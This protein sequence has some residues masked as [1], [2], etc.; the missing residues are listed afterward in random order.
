MQKKSYWQERSKYSLFPIMCRL[1]KAAFTECPV[2]MLVYSLVLF[3]NGVIQVVITYGTELFFDC[4]SLGAREREM[5]S[6]IIFSFLFLMAAIL[7]SHILNGCDNYLGTSVHVV[8]IGK[9]E[10]RMHKKAVKLDPALFEDTEFLDNINK[11]FQGSGVSGCTFV[12]E[13]FMVVMFSQ[14]P[15]MILMSSYLYTRKPILS[16]CIFLVFVPVVISQY[17]RIHVFAKLEDETVPCRREY[18]CYHECVTGREYF[19]ETR[20]LGAY[21]FFSGLI[22]ET[23]EKINGRAWKCYGKMAGLE[24]LMRSI[25]LLGYAGVLLLLVYYVLNGSLGVGAFAAVFS[26]IAVMFETIESAVGQQ[27]GGAFE[28]MGMVTNYVRFLDMEEMRGEEAAVDYSKGIQIHNV[29]FSYK[30]SE[31]MAVKNASLTI[32]NG[33]TLAIV[34]ENGAGKSTLVKLLIGS[35]RPDQ[36]EVRIGQVNTEN[37]KMQCYQRKISGVFQNYQKYKMTL[38]DNVIISASGEQKPDKVKQI[39]EDVDVDMNGTDY[40]KGLDTVLSTEF[41]GTDI[42]GG[43]WQRVAIARGMY[44]EHEV[45]IL[46]EPTAAIDPIEEYALYHKFKAM[47]KDK[48]A[49][50]V[51]HRMGSC[52]IADRIVVMDKGQ[53]IEEGTHEELMHKNGKYREMYA[54]QAQWYAD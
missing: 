24:I 8:L 20:M 25:T 17:I 36:G 4:V 10:K 52:K 43:Q 21:R 16:I 47:A 30:G 51:T 49:I 32:R 12:L 1:Y 7:A 42:S 18:A 50:L 45:I 15:Y 38:E 9:F 26:S 2:R 23:I 40:P 22:R 31:E 6:M 53:I 29:S 54:A 37:T 39:L 46:D 27:L 35:Y 19:K 14:V 34:G 3:A 5:S 48:T 28:K 33:E 13:A 44:K 41:G 11:A